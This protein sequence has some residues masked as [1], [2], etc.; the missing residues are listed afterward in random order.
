MANEE[1]LSVKI[2]AKTDEFVKSLDDI[3][4]R[5]STIGQEMK[6]IDKQLKTESIDKVKKLAEKLD[7]VQRQAG[8]AEKEAEK[9]RQ[10]IENISK[11][12]ENG[13]ELTEKQKQKIEEL[14]EKMALAEQKAA[15]YAAQADDLSKNIK[16]MAEE[17]ENAGKETGELA[18]G[19]EDVGEESAEAGQKTSVFADVL[20]GSL[21]S[22]AIMSGV[23]MLG[24][25]MHTLWQKATE[26]AKAIWNYS[27]EAVDMAADY[28]DA[29]GYSEQVFED[30]A[31]A[32]Q[33]WVN[34]NSYA[35]RINKSDL[36]SYV[37]QLGSL[38]RSFGMST[39]AAAKY[40]ES[41][42]QLAVDLHAATGTDTGQIIDNM[43]SIMTGGYK[44]G[45]KYGIVINEAAVKTKA[46]SMGL[47]DM[48]VNQKDV[49]KATL[50][51]TEANV[52][53]AKAYN[54]YGEDSIEYKKALMEVANA[55]AA[56]DKA[57]GGKEVALTQAQ[58]EQA[59]YQL[60]LEQTAT[61][62]GQAARESKSYK[63]Q[64]D[65]MKVTFDNLK[66]SI[67]EKL[68]P[69]F[70]EFMKKANEFVQ[71]E[72][73]QKMLDSIVEKV[74]EIAA[75]VKEFIESGQL[76]E[77]IK[78]FEEN[79]P[80]IVKD[81]TDLAKVVGDLVQPVLDL[82]RAIQGYNDLKAMDEAIKSSKKEV[83]AFADSV[84]VDMDTLRI[85]IKGFAE[86]NNVS[87]TEIYGDWS[88]YQPQIAEYMAS[89]GTISEEMK[90]K[91]NAATGEMASQTKSDLDATASAFQDGLTQA[92]NVDTTALQ[93]KTQEVESLGSRIRN[94]LAN[95][96]DNSG[97]FKNAPG[98]EYAHRAGG[99]P[100]YPG[101]IYQVNDDHGRRNELFIP[102][103]SGYI[104]NGSD[105]ERVINNTSTNNSQTYGDT[106]VYVNSYGTN[107]VAIADEIGLEVSQRLRMSGSPW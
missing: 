19:I 52:K 27:K 28:Q 104:L 73:G 54:Q 46:L 21:L 59:I 67:G 102:S 65:G 92:G 77:W 17:S 7:L 4:K 43:T 68:L 41:L 56:V 29:L 39:D 24:D 88:S 94:A 82:Y 1:T 13:A 53:A 98:A 11:T 47:V 32:V 5:C 107:A 26:A 89:T 12:S 45:Y 2:Q 22:N 55:E 20:K 37:N 72:Q 30:Q 101:Q 18:D 64:L 14:A 16:E 96:I 69:V 97:W 75:K 8:L 9:Y 38:Y 71:S 36:Q 31:E 57:L 63:S 90:N 106:Y 23:K 105:T 25:L 42:L 61:A 34:A 83:H 99:G 48:E 70:T 44:A 80:G 86:L 78:K 58:K 103:V 49:E 100:A 81:L 40:S 79:L 60:I 62:E 33:N 84:N 76:D 87:L 35:L 3:K 93:A 66:I 85:A 74:G 51:L 6:E 15:T 50:K 91:V 95:F 10:E